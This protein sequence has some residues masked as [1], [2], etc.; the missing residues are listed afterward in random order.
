MGFEREF[1]VLIEIKDIEEPPCELYNSE[2]RYIGTIWNVLSFNDV[3]IQIAEQKAEGYYIMFKGERVEI[4]NDGQ[5]KQK[6]PEGMFNVHLDQ[7][8]KLLNLR[9][10]EGDDDG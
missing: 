7:M 2:G 6:Y 3:R 1:I 8:R 9:I 4:H 10:Y 5:I